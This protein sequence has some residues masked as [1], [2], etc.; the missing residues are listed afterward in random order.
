MY[1][2]EGEIDPRTPIVGTR[3]EHCDNHRN[4]TVIDKAYPQ[5]LAHL[6]ATNSLSANEMMKFQID[7]VLGWIDQKIGRPHLCRCQQPRHKHSAGQH[8][9]DGL[10]RC[11]N[12][13]SVPLRYFFRQ[14]SRF[15]PGYSRLSIVSIFRSL[16]GRENLESSSSKRK[17]RGRVA[18][19]LQNF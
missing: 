11:R 17:C 2:G 18:E 9:R 6:I 3:I 8:T 10:H 14:A 16:A 12:L 4:P 1:S 15:H 13:S 5:A 7:I 19:S